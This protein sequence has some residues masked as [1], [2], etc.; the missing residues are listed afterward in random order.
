MLMNGVMVL[1]HHPV[2]TQHPAL[3]QIA[4]LRLLLSTQPRV[5]QQALA[6]EADRSRGVIL[7]EEQHRALQAQVADLALLRESNTTLRCVRCSVCWNTPPPPQQPHSIIGFGVPLAP[8]QCM[9]KLLHQP[10][11]S[12]AGVG[13]GYPA[14]VKLRL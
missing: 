12:H 7:A 6:A 3:Q 8:S 2:E 10:G 4:M 13:R 14:V 1:A 9:C 11:D 5:I